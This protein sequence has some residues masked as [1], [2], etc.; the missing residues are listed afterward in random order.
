[1]LDECWPILSLTVCDIV[2]SFHLIDQIGS[3]NTEIRGY[4]QCTW[5]VCLCECAGGFRSID[6]WMSRRVDSKG[7]MIQRF[8][9]FAKIKQKFCKRTLCCVSDESFIIPLCV[10]V[11]WDASMGI[12]NEFEHVELLFVYLFVILYR[13]IVL[14]QCT[15][16]PAPIVCIQC[17]EWL[18][19]VWFVVVVIHRFFSA[20]SHSMNIYGCICKLFVFLY[21]CIWIHWNLFFCELCLCLFFN[22]LFFTLC[23]P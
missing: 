23:A 16:I 20:L 13:C 19:I 6:W 2:R 5:S 21:T 3:W 7:D 17:S 1:M 9:A 22:P 18:E 15:I 11:L 10:C 14:C 4:C 12:Q 8:V